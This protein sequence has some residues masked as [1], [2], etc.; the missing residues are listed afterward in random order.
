VAKKVTV[1]SA[2]SVIYIVRNRKEA[3]L[4]VNVEVLYKRYGPMV[5]RRCRQ[6]LQDEQNAL[7]AMQETFVKVLRYQKRLEERYPSGLLYRIATNT[8]LNM[9][10]ARIRQPVSA[11][12]DLLLFIASSDDT[13]KTV[14]VRDLLHR[15]FRNEK[16]STKEIA[17][18]YYIDGMTHEEVASEVGLSVSGVRKRLR[19]LKQRASGFTELSGG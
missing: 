14:W 7:D 2:R 9:L 6:L 15:I 10:R 1:F 5:L 17:V 18:M 12:N 13:E 11:D 4:P 3:I 19:M 8:C 16:A